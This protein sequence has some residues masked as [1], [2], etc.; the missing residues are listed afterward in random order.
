M[1]RLRLGSI[2]L[3]GVLLLSAS[4]CKRTETEGD[5]A[6]GAE[7]PSSAE[8]DRG[9][10]D[11]QGE[12]P[13]SL[14]TQ[15]REPARVRLDGTA[16]LL[17]VSAVGSGPRV[18]SRQIRTWIYEEPSSSS[19]RLGYFRAGASSPTSDAPA[20]FDGCRK[21]WYPVQPAGYVCV[22][23]HATLDPNDPV[24]RALETRRPRSDTKLPYI[25]G[26]V[27]NPGP[28]YQRLPSMDELREAEADIDTR[29]T[30]WLEAGGEIGA[31]YAQHVWTWGET[32]E[33][34]RGAWTAK[35]T[36]GV[37]E[38]LHGGAR[39]PNPLLS[40]RPETLLLETMRPKVGY[41]LLETF[42]HEGRRY[43]I[44]TQLEI[45]P[46]DRLRPIQGSDF[47]GVQIGKDIDF[48]FAF[49]RSPEAKFVSAS[50]AVLG[51]ATYRDVLKLSG[52]Q[53]FFNNVLHYETTDGRYISDRHASR[54]DPAKKMPGW[55]LAG[56]KWIDINITKQ[57]L[58]LYE[59]TEPVYATLV[60]TGEA[61]LASAE[62]TTATRRGIF[63]VHTK[64]ITATMA[65]SESG[66]EFELR[67][68]PY[69]QYFES[70]GYA[71][72]GAY[73]HDRFGT[74]KSHGCINLSPE[75][76]RRVFYWTDPQ[77]PTGWHGALLPL[78]GTVVFIHR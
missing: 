20:G 29:M 40:P 57:T 32:P 54:L 22:G 44:T 12:S 43:G 67:D 49:V 17:A 55:A 19:R 39:I 37:P 78:K 73:W 51:D 27:R 60:S 21:G 46:T 41:A 6:D 68:V 16:E 72:H 76:A 5:Q 65:S 7:L 77:V 59:G 75:D 53:Q 45:V 24:V 70:D 31:G 69:V 13:E 30:R 74:P 56:E 52:K 28:V 42:F 61:G 1:A 47:R 15:A 4:S 58:M 62:D 9:A 63:R 11:P 33:D 34:P 25:Y 71:L 18:Y 50:G 36:R 48:P 35:L 3:G 64:H 38:F 8:P 26:T 66:E 2:V 23:T 14:D 10:L